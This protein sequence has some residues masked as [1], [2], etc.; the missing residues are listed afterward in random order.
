[1]PVVQERL[2]A[3]D[4]TLALMPDFAP[5]RFVAAMVFVA[6]DPSFLWLGLFLVAFFFTFSAAAGEQRKAWPYLLTVV[7]GWAVMLLPGSVLLPEL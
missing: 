3:V 7:A 2:D 6:P 5:A 1:M 4:R